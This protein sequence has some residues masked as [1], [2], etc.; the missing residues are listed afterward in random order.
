MCS[1]IGSAGACPGLMAAGEEESSLCGGGVRL[2]VIDAGSGSRVNVISSSLRKE[3]Y[4]EEYNL[5][6]A[7]A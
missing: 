1:A 7:N 6:C 3:I 2:G 4:R 5:H